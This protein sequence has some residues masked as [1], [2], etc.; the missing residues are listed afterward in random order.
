MFGF[1]RASCAS[2]MPHHVSKAP[3]LKVPIQRSCLGE[4]EKVAG[5]AVE[6]LRDT[7]TNEQMPRAVETHKEAWTVSLKL[8][9]FTGEERNAAQQRIS[10]WWRNLIQL[11]A[12]WSSM[13][14]VG[15]DIRITPST[16]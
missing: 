15:E 16:S 4:M 2:F 5:I 12:H 14:S 8:R 3:I 10:R 9:N 1:I 6:S 7:H 11:S 13:L